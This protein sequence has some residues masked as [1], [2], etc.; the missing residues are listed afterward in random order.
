MLTNSSIG[1]RLLA[2]WFS[3]FQP[4]IAF[5]PE[6][7]LMHNVN[8]PL[9]KSALFSS[10]RSYPGINQFQTGNPANP[11]PGPNPGPDTNVTINYNYLIGTPGPPGPTGP[12]GPPGANGADGADGA[13]GSCTCPD[14][15]EA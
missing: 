2:D 12:T 11:V 4:T 5:Q 10:G 14:T 15:L 1:S 7:L 9:A 13:D 8:G 6:R 3:E